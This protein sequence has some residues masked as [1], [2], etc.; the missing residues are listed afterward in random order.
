MFKKPQQDGFITMLLLM[1]IVIGTVV[2][3]AYSRVA[4]AK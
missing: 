1:I 2:Y 3:L 4:G